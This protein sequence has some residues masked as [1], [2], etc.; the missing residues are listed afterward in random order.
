ML[1]LFYQ[2]VYDTAA[3]A[4]TATSRPRLLQLISFRAAL[5]Y[6]WAH[7]TIARHFTSQIPLSS[8]Q[9]R[10]SVVLILPT[11]PIIRIK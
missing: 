5:D 4:A 7:I 11:N 9:P 10:K 2:L 3:A 1:F 8:N 6:A